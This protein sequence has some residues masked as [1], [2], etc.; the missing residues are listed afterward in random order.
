MMVGQ[1]AIVTS[2]ARGIGRGISEVLTAAGMRVAIVQP[3]L[4]SAR[5]A[6]NEMAGARGFAADVRDREQ[7]NAM[8]ASV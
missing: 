2:G 4:D 7:V 8:V 6:A 1:V 5:R 3:D